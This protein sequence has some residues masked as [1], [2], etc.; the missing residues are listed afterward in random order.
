MK[1]ILITAFEPFGGRA[2]NTSAE[3]CR[4]LPETIG[5]CE[6][7]KIILPVVFRKAAETVLRHQADS[8]F[9]LGEA[10]GRSAVTPELRAGNIRN[11]RIPDN[12]GCRPAGE[13]ILAEGPEEYRTAF[14]VERIVRRMREEGREIAVSGD[15]G[16]FVCNETYYLTGTGSR[17]PAVFIHV[18][19]DPER[20]ADFAETVRRFIELAVPEI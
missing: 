16:T 20:A 9:M 3:V 12:A 1:Q 13:M 2:V 11:A 5:G 17:I 19:D 6:T 18:P 7:T 8:I 10:G 4:L 14:P 15:A